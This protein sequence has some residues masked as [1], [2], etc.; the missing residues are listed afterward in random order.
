M[1]KLIIS[2]FTF[3]FGNCSHISTFP[4]MNHFRY[5]ISVG[6]TLCFL[7]FK[8]SSEILLCRSACRR[9]YCM[10]LLH[11]ASGISQVRGEA[12]R[13]QLRLSRSDRRSDM[14]SLNTEERGGQDCHILYD[15]FA[16]PLIFIRE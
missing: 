9:H 12:P 5:G 13:L 15:K 10:N 4:H 2:G 14:A 3:K 1:S 8:I 11:A 7:S 6:N 16:H